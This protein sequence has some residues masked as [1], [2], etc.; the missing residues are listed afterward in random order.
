VSAIVVTATW[1]ARPVGSAIGAAVGAL[2]GAEACLVVAATG[3]LVQ[4]AIIF[5]SPVPHLVRQPEPA[6]GG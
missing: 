4:A 6:P 3:F 2:G 1:G 5:T